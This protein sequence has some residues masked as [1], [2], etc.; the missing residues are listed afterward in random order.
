MGTH[1]W[2]EANAES[3]NVFETK[4]FVK[5]Y[6]KELLQKI[7]L[8]N[9]G[10]LRNLHIRPPTHPPTLRIHHHLVSSKIRQN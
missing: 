1:L 9:Y 8:M 3:L 7:L 5:E 2:S 4:I 6:K 10:I